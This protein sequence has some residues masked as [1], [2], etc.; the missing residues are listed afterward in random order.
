MP[1]RSY[2]DALHHAR[3]IA[4]DAIDQIYTR[5]PDTINYMNE[6]ANASIQGDTII[7][8]TSDGDMSV[9]FAP[10]VDDFS[11][12]RMYDVKPFNHYEF[13]GTISPD[14]EEKPAELSWEEMMFGKEK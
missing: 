10:Y 6:W 4:T 9:E 14:N 12:A 1:P 13:Y 8:T 2:E 5:H 7:T 11:A 3:I